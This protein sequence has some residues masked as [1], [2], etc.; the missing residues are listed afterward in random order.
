MKPVP[1]LALRLAPAAVMPDRFVVHTPTDLVAEIF[2]ACRHGATVLFAPP[3]RDRPAGP[4]HVLTDAEIRAIPVLRAVARRLPPEWR[5]FAVEWRDGAAVITG[6]PRS[7]GEPPES[8][9]RSARRAAV[10]SGDRA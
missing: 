9:L 1:A 2:A 7:C 5:V 3:R 10:A 8:W 6:A 4:A